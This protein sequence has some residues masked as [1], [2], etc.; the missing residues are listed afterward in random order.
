MKENTYRREK[1]LIVSIIGSVLVMV[2]YSNYIYLKYIDG[3]TAVLNDF[4]FWGKSFLV[5]VPIAIVTQI[6]IHIIF[7]I[8]NKIV[9]DEDVPAITDERDK[10]ID[11]KAIKISHWIFVSGFMLA[12][13]SLALGMQPWVMFVTL[14]YSGFISSITSEIIKVYYY[15]RG[16]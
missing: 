5:L 1:Q 13:G 14:I 15:R 3:N 2:F 9:T 8:I 16:F 10:L 6:V 12:M 7:F 4:K 11:L